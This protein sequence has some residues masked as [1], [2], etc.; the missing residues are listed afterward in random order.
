MYGMEGGVMDRHTVRVS[1]ALCV[2]VPGR[3]GWRCW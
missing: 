1:V 3:V 2:P